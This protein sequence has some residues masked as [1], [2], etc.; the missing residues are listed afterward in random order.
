VGHGDYGRLTPEAVDQVWGRLR[1]GQAAKPTAREL[2]L[3]TRTVRR[4]CFAAAASGSLV[5]EP[6]AVCG[7]M[8]ARRSPA[9]WPL[10]NWI[11]VLPLG[12]AS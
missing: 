5:G 12:A 4:I 11:G 6:R 7:S 9:V 2:G 1:A 10:T 8:S 3:Y